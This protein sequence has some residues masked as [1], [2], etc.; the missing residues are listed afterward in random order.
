MRYIVAV[1]IGIIVWYLLTIGFGIAWAILGIPYAPT[2]STV[3][4]LVLL[5]IGLFVGWRVATRKQ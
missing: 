5:P 2:H 4:N 3:L 1:V